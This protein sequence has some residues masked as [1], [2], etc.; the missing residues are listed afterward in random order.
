ME[1]EPDPAVRGEQTECVAELNPGEF[2]WEVYE[3][4]VR[5]LLD[6]FFGDPFG[7]EDFD[8]EDG[9]YDE[10]E[11]SAS[12]TG[13]ADGE[14]FAPFAFTLAVDGDAEV[15]IAVASQDDAV[16]FYAGEI[17]PADDTT[18][19]PPREPVDTDEED[20]A[21]PVAVRRPNRVE[22]GGG[23]AAPDSGVPA[24]GAAIVLGLALTA[25]VA[26]RRSVTQGR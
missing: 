24:G 18:P 2:E 21:A 13:L 17:E 3:L 26:V 19:A 10:I 12:G 14:G 9:E 25:A 11:P 16:A 4:T 1:C 8:E 20:A 23:G 5:D 7:D 15:F 22:A 6:E